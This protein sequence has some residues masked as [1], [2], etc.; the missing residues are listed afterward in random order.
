M[1][2][3]HQLWV[4]TDLQGWRHLL[5]TSVPASCAYSPSVG[6]EDSTFAVSCTS[7]DGHAYAASVALPHDG[8]VPRM[9]MLRYQGGISVSGPT[10]FFRDYRAAL[11][12]VSQQHGRGNVYLRNLRDPAG[13]YT[14][15]EGL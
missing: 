3:D 9:P 12:V 14:Q 15:A 10:V 4:R 5:V 7:A 2:T 13:D 1:G 11:A 8:S 6:I